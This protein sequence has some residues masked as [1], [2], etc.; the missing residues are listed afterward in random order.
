MASIIQQRYFAQARFSLEYTSKSGG[1]NFISKRR[2]M[3]SFPSSKIL[4]TSQYNRQGFALDYRLDVDNL[5]LSIGSE[6]VLPI[7]ND[8]W[9]PEWSGDITEQ[10]DILVR[11]GDT[12]GANLPWFPF[13]DSVLLFWWIHKEELSLPVSV[14]WRREAGGLIKLEVHI[15]AHPW[16]DPLL[17]VEVRGK[18]TSTI[19]VAVPERPLSSSPSMT[20]P[21]RVAIIHVIAPTAVIVNELLGN[22]LGAVIELVATALYIMLLLFMYGFMALAVVFSLWRCF[23]GPSF[24]DTVE[25]L[26]GRLGRLSQNERL[27]F[28]KIDALRENLDLLY[29][30][31]KFK[32]VINICRNG[33][34]PERDR[35]RVAEE[36]EADIEK[37][38][39]ATG[40]GEGEE[41]GKGDS[42]KQ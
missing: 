42:R 6:H 18:D 41:E 40:E 21:I 14:Q 8:Q 12:D 9:A 36:E 25:G 22:V 2:L 26:Q 39:N 24:E 16:D 5:T 3:S 23:R 19:T 30:N 37:G 17:T 27:R 15:A 4:L 35:E 32:A 28:L 33:W 38:L 1:A 34:H 10:I 29:Q 7:I 13:A 20:Y 31:K 11:I